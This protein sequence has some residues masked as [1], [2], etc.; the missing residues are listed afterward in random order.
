MACCPVGRPASSNPP[1]ESVTTHLC[2]PG[3]EIITPAIGSPLQQEIP[4]PG[5]R[6]VVSACSCSNE[7]MIAVVTSCI[8]LYNTTPWHTFPRLYTPFSFSRTIPLLGAFHRT[9][10]PMTKGRWHESSVRDGLHL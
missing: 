7:A 8:S 9:G 5:I 1:V 2:T 6:P 10:S 3:A 4:V